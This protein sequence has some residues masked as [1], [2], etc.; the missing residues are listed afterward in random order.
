MIKEN[1]LK[2]EEKKEKA[3]TEAAENGSLMAA[4]NGKVLPRPSWRWRTLTGDSDEETDF[5]KMDMGKQKGACW[6]MG[7]DTLRSIPSTCPVERLA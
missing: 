4:D 5:S 2:K 6:Q 3:K 7:F 1:L